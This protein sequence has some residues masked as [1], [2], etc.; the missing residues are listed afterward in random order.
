M[1]AEEGMGEDGEGFAQS[2]RFLRI[3]LSPW[4]FVGLRP[5]IAL[6]GS[7]SHERTSAN[8]GGRSEGLRP[9]AAGYIRGSAPNKQGL[10]RSARIPNETRKASG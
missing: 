4:D 6:R 7:A 10:A 5:P 9:G 8:G 3:P 2:L 1:K